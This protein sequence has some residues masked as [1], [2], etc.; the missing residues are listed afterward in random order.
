LT[1]QETIDQSSF[2]KAAIRLMNLDQTTN[3]T[4]ETILQEYQQKQSKNYQLQQ[5]NKQQNSQITQQ[6]QVKKTQKRNP[7]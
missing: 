4:Y 2:T 3:K 1:S 7:D 6:K 5:K